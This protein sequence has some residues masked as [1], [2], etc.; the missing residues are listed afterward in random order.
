[1]TAGD[2]DARRVL[3][4]RASSVERVR[5]PS[6][7]RSWYELPV[8]ADLQVR[9]RAFR[10]A[11]TVGRSA[12]RWRFRGVRCGDTCG[13]RRVPD[14]GPGGVHARRHQ[15]R[16]S[17][18]SPAMA[19]PCPTRR[20]GRGWHRWRRHGAQSRRQRAVGLGPCVRDLD[21]NRHRDRE[22]T[23]AGLS[24]GPRAGALAAFG[25][26]WP[27]GIGHRPRLGDRLARRLARV[28]DRHQGW[29]ENPEDMARPACSCSMPRRWSCSGYQPT[30][31]FVRWRS[32]PTA[33]PLRRGHARLRWLRPAARRPGRVDHR[34]RH[35][36]RQ[37][38]RDRRPARRHHR[39]RAPAAR[40]SECQPPVG[41]GGGT[42]TEPGRDLG[43]AEREPPHQ[44][45]GEEGHEEGRGARRRRRR[46]SWEALDRGARPEGSSPSVMSG[47][48]AGGSAAGLVQRSMV[49]V[50]RSQPS[51]DTVA[52]PSS[53]GGPGSAAH[54][55]SAPQ[56]A[57]DVAVRKDQHVVVGL[58]HARDHPIDPAATS[59]RLATASG[60]PAQTVQPGRSARISVRRRPSSSP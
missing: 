53:R 43:G 37:G 32:A 13:R 59:G 47:G 31:D 14:G 24:T 12:G 22:T 19:G 57:Q 5:E 9:Q 36:G 29:R 4:R 11:F 20:P 33:G 34:L 3:G 39:L 23:G 27:R 58:A 41:S 54:R 56:D 55:P 16:R 45:R 52:V 25:R 28:R 46:R 1:M 50:S 30:A 51:T 26:G 6:S 8:R 48:R 35:G 44:G 21:A 15:R 38:S 2:G 40:W 7:A 60:R 17:A 49:G 10:A 18:G 42:R